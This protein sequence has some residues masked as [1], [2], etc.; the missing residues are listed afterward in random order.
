MFYQEGAIKLQYKASLIIL[1]F[2]I[3]LLVI[4]VGGFTYYNEKAAIKSG[5]KGLEA[6]AGE[7]SSHLESHLLEAATVATTLSSA[8]LITDALNQSNH[9]YLQLS[10][11]GRIKR[12]DQLNKQWMSAENAFDP[13]IVQHMSNPTA[14]FLVQQQELFP[15]VYG[16]IF[17]TNRYGVMIASTGKLTT[18][19]HAQKYWWKASYN[20]GVGK[21]F[22]DD[23]GFDTSVGDYVL[24][25]VVPVFQRGEV[26]GIVKANINILGP[27]RELI[28]AVR[29]KHGV[30]AKLVRSNGLI[31]YEQ[32]V[33]PL[34]S[35]V[36]SELERC[37]G[38]HENTSLS[39]PVSSSLVACSPVVITIESEEYGF[40]GKGQSIDQLKGNVDETWSILISEEIELALAAAHETAKE[41]IVIG[42]LIVLFAAGLALVLGR[43]AARPVVVLSDIAKTIGEGSLE[44]RAPK[45]ADDEIG[46]LADSVN[47]MA[48]NLQAT[49]ASRDELQH[50]IDLRIK[51]EE[52]LRLLSTSVE[53]A[54]EAISISDMDGT[55]A[56]V[57]PAFT[58]ITGYTAQEAIGANHNLLNSGCQSSAFYK[59][60]WDTIKSG[61]AWQGRIVD[62]TKDGELYP[63][64]MTISPIFDEKSEITHFVGIQQ[65]LKEYEEMEQKVR[66]AQKMEA[67]GTL[68]GG[69]A[70]DFNNRLA[71][72]TGN[73]YLAKKRVNN[74]PE[75]IKNLEVIEKQSFQVAEIIKRLLIFTSRD[76]ISLLPFDLACSVRGALAASRRLMPENIS[77]YQDICEQKLIVNGDAGQC[78]KAMIGLLDNAMDA[79]A[80]IEMPEIHLKVEQVTADKEFTAAHPELKGDQFA[81]IIIS[82]NGCGI[83]EKDMPHLFEPFFTTKGVEPGK[84]LGLSMVYGAVQHMGGIVKVDNNAD[85]GARVDIYLPLMEA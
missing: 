24:G 44:T 73:L 4:L 58:L 71:G 72:I 37:V 83:S 78:Q 47:A 52:S 43:L 59:E 45:G 85:S 75:L 53:Q 20:S 14:E 60:M 54:K 57:N 8:P 63:A 68:I 28:D 6:L 11:T 64:M 67:L 77:V 18:L 2:S 84:G 32:G 50:E 29:M 55:I 61:R 25:V 40:G 33:I 46:S 69:V 74:Q 49:M 3:A 27:I 1:L 42:M 66:Q 26:I 79:V 5:Q 22:F 23:R 9:E 39:D 41:L 15:G 30:V 38:S 35:V 56:Y 10:E 81:H 76:I 34:G 70:H 36:S 19:V 7:I 12:I 16:E 31:V 21:V 51:A 17:I 62:R 13:F 82:D 80:L 65:G 48:I